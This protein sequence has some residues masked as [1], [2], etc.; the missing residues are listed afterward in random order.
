MTSLSKFSKE[1][2]ALIISVPYRVG[3]WISMVD[4]NKKTKVDDKREM[5]SLVAAISN[6]S[7]RSQKMP[8]AATIMSDVEAHKGMWS[9]WDAQAEEAIILRDLEKALSLCGEK[10]TKG[11]VS[12]YKYAVWQLGIVVAQAFGEHIDP[13]NEMHVNN[14]FAWCGDLV[15]RPTLGKNPENMSKREKTALKKLRAVLKG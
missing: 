1:E 2:R 4:D 3:I 8:F 10:S 5:R 13:D 9:V 12:Q 11:E 14:F 7:S 6:L 15:G